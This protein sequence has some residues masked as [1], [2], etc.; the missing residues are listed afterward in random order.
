MSSTGT[1][2]SYPENQDGKAPKL[3]TYDTPLPVT[4]YYLELAIHDIKSDY[5]DTVSILEKNKNLVKFG[6][7]EQVDNTAGGTSIMTLP[8]G[9]RHEADIYENLIDSVSSSNVA[10]AGKTLVVEGHYFNGNDDLVFHVQDVTLDATNPTTTAAALSQP[11]GRTTRAYLKNSGV[12]GSPQSDLQGDIYFYDDTGGVTLSGGVPSVPAQVH[13]MIRAGQN[14]T[15]KACTS[16][17]AEDYWIV[18]GVYADMLDKA[19]SASAELALETRDV[20]N[21]GV[22]LKQFDLKCSHSGSAFRVSEP[23]IVVPKNY[24]IRLI[25]IGDSAGARSVSAGIF[26]VLAKVVS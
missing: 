1:F 6:R 11:L 26:G 2:L 5:G 7:S 8:S 3:V 13:M 20:K 9:V 18:V 14:K 17:S 23:Y 16:V 12:F 25:G 10:D 4:N 19:T 22:F 21:G 15:E 24:D